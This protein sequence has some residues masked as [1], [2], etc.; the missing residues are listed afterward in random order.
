MAFGSKMG[1]TASI[2][3]RLVETLRGRGLEASLQTARK[4]RSLDGFDATV[5][6]SAIYASRWRP[7]AVHLLRRMAKSGPHIPVWLF[8]SGP[9]GVEG[10]PEAQPLPKDVRSFADQ[11]DTRD[12]ITFGGRLRDNPKGF[13]AKLIAKNRAGDWRDFDR[14]LDW[15]NAIADALAAIETQA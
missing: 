3:E 1:G 9:L 10:T 7:E 5:V 11:L 2:A 8:H 13:V 14:V 15:A 6:G 4:V 12:V